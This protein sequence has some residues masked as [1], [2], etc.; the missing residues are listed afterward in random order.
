MSIRSNYV[1]EE[2][3]PEVLLI[4]D[5]GPWETHPTIT[6]DVERVVEDLAPKLVGR[7]LEYYDSEGCRDQILIKDGKFVGFAPAVRR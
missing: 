2:D 7:R 3:R 4:R 5:L 1:I 6:T